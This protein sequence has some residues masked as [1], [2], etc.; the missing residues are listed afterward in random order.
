MGHNQKRIGL[1]TCGP[2]SLL[3]AGVTSLLRTDAGPIVAGLVTYV[4]SK[5]R[6]LRLLQSVLEVLRDT[7]VPPLMMMMHGA[8]AFARVHPGRRN[9]S[10][11]GGGAPTVAVA[12]FPNERRAIAELKRMAP[13]RRWWD[14]E[15]ALGP[16]AIVAAAWHLA[17]T[18]WRGWR[19]TTRVV[20]RV[21][22]RRGLF[23]AMRVMELLFYYRRYYDFFAQAAVG[24]AVVSNHTNPHGLAFNLAAR[25]FGVRTVL[26]THGMPIRPIARLDF[27]VAI[28]ENRA[29]RQ[30]YEEAGWRIGRW[31]LKPRRLDYVPFK[32][33]ASFDRLT[34]GV[35]LSKDPREDR[36]IE[37]L[38]ALLSDTR[39]AAVIVRPH[40]LNL[41]AGLGARLERLRDSRLTLSAGGPVS[42]DLAACDLVTAGNS[43]I[44]VEAVTAGIPSCYVRDLD[45]GPYDEQSFVR[46]GLICQMAGL[47]LQP[48]GVVTFYQREQ[49]PG[50]LRKYACVDAGEEEFAPAVA[51][52]LESGG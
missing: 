7:P 25:R 5:R 29:C 6:W 47:S 39:V 36:V 8:I 18:P 43:T 4:L 12:R 21:I 30:M 40:P 2:P 37:L 42:D 3:Y 24:C 52:A 34:V 27:D 10:A 14:F 1:P 26:V 28:V 17:A 41:W 20:R 16:A 35:L 19:R 51:A 9:A 13:D 49:W 48:A 23:H 31:I 22:D 32:P 11:G 50:V 45:H 15:F 44:H 38:R 46:D 33:P